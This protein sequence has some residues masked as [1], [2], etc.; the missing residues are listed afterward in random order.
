MKAAQIKEYG[1]NVIAINENAEK[2]GI[3]AEQVLVEVYASGLNPVDWKIR[4]GYLQKMAPLHFPAT[5]GS[6]FSG[7]IIEVGEGV[8]SFKK[9]DEVYGSAIALGEGSGALAEFAVASAK[10]I[11]LKPGK[12]DYIQAAALPLAGVSALQALTEHIN[13][14]K[15]QKLLIQGGGG[16]IGSI[17]IQIA[18][19]LGAYVAATV[20]AK[21]AEYV[22]E[23]GADEVIDY[24]NEDFATIV[25]EYDAVFDMVGGETYAKSFQVLKKGGILVSMV[26]QP[27]QELMKKYEVKAEGQYTQINAEKLN[28]LSE[29]V[30]TGIVKVHIDKIFPLEQAGEALLYLQKGHPRGKVVVKIR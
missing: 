5:L 19:H 13:L 21:D 12:T 8:K 28:K 26:E 20:S 1:E 10:T 29:L 9:G 7:K 2:P 22:R 3:T 17:A 27:N 15:G 23:L 4:E 24:K 30:D 11:A 25:K 18:K 14:Q 6:D 16:G